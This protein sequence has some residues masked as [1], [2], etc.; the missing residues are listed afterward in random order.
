VKGIAEEV[1]IQ[2]C[3]MTVW[4]GSTHIQ[5]STSHTHI[6]THTSDIR[7]YS[8]CRTAAASCRGCTGPSL[9]LYKS[10]TLI[11]THKHTFTF[12][13]PAV[14][15]LPPAE[16]GWVPL[17]PHWAI[18]PESE[19][20]LLGAGHASD[21]WQGGWSTGCLRALSSAPV[22]VCVCVCVC[23][24]AVKCVTASKYLH[25]YKKQVLNLRCVPLHHTL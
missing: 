24:R 18:L 7:I 14:L 21:P 9:S 3:F 15:Q 4:V 1:P 25:I 6:H 12:I 17:D 2:H 13:I 20:Q 5:A 19:E 22:C 8:T 16:G 11:H 23:V 10:H